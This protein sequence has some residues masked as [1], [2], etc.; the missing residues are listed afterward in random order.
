MQKPIIKKP[1]WLRGINFC[2]GLCAPVLLF[3]LA[4]SISGC[5]G[6][7]AEQIEL[8]RAE[9]F[10]L[11]QDQ[12][13]LKHQIIVLDS[14]IGQKVQAL[15][16]FS[17]D[18][19]TD[20]RSLSQ[21]LSVIEQRLADTE[22]LLLRLQG[23]VSAATLAPPGGGQTQPEKAQPQKISATEIFDIAYKDFNSSKHQ[24]AI[25]GFS[26][27]IERFPDNPM[28]AEAYFYIGSSYQAL[29]KYEKAIESYK[30]I[31]ERFPDLQQHPD[32]LV[33]IGDCLIKLGEKSRAEFYYESVIQRFPDS[34]AAAHARAR[35]NP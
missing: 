9:V 8:L 33:R 27:F 2:V 11:K 14:L 7:S 34:D 22:G 5:G 20:V 23:R 4:V 17:A 29:K 32:A 31:A 3:G 19:G 25:E 6:A 24:L 18:F 15:D 21:R 10:S 1:G 13:Q 28:A 30:T 16:N 35:L 12:R 26:D